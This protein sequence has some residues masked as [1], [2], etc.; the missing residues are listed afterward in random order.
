VTEQ[1]DLA[2]AVR[3]VEAAALAIV[4]DPDAA[5]SVASL[6][7][8]AAG[9]IVLVVGPE[10]GVSPTEADAFRDAGA[11]SAAL[12]PT[13]LRGST[14]GVVAAGIVLSQTDRWQGRATD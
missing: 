2:A 8:P 14:A 11:V 1:A 6:T 10:G 13:V 4:L 9:E 5:A 12:G 3:R 7:L